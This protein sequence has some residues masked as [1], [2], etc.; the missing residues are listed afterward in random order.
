MK[1]FSSQRAVYRLLFATGALCVG[2]FAALGAEKIQISTPEKSASQPTAPAVRSTGD[3]PGV[4]TGELLKGVSSGGVDVPSFAAPTGARTLDPKTQKLLLEALNKKKDEESLVTEGSEFERDGSRKVDGDFEPSFEEDGKKGT[5]KDR[6]EGRVGA[7]ENGRDGVRSNGRD[8]DRLQSR[9]GMRD[10]DAKP[11]SRTLPTLN[12]SPL[13]SPVDSLGLNSPGR[14]RYS[15]KGE[16]ILVSD[17]S[18]FRG[19]LDSQRDLDLGLGVDKR[20]ALDGL[21]PKDGTRQ[22]GFRNMLEGVKEGNSAGRNSLVNSLGAG[23]PADR[24]SQFRTLLNGAPTAP[25]SLLPAGA[26]PVDLLK[27]PTAGSSFS[28]SSVLPGSLLPSS[29]PS[30]GS[31][32]PSSLASPTPASVGIKPQPIVLPLPRRF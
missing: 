17:P 18:D 27:T 12:D 16:K 28:G 26:T 2:G 24:Q 25:K 9:D 21:D 11:G 30:G 22:Q 20:E 1:T 31:L 14:D 6:R 23:A 32:F 7:G 4:T 15:V 3:R 10:R 19:S 13:S 29:S 8:R 5:G